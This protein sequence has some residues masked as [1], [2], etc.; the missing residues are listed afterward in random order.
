MKILYLTHR[1]PPEHFRGTEVYTWELAREMQRRGHN[2]LVVTLREMKKEETGLSMVRDSYAE[3]PVARICK[4]LRPD[5]FESYFFDAEMDKMFLDLTNEFQP[6]IIHSTYFLGGLSLGMSL[7][8][9]EMGKLFITITDYSAICARGQ[10]LDR[11]LKLC[12]GPRNGVRC[13]YCLF[14][15]NWLFKNPGLDKWAREYL[16]IWIGRLKDV[17]ELD[18]IRKRNQAIA[19]I[20]ASARS[21]I[22]AHP[23]TLLVFNREKI[24]LS[25]PRLL[26]FGVDY[27][28][29]REHKKNPSD[30]LRIGFIGQ[31]LPHK[32]LHIL[33][34]ALAG[35]PEQTK[36]ELKIYGSL[37]DPA[38]K[39]YFDSLSLSRIKNQN[40]LGTFDYSQMNKVLEEIDLLVVPSIWPENCPL[41]P[42]YA[43][44]TGT[45]LLL[46]DAP[47]ILVKAGGQGI[48][49]AGIGKVMMLREKIEDLIKTQAWQGRLDPSA[50]LVMR[51]QDHASALERIY[52][53]EG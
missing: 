41:I 32:G 14:D 18:L 36:F 33:V 6:D 19:N 2:V 39:T 4:H 21:V 50:G 34:E 12:P 9:A 35:I 47:G 17:W 37:S 28:P 27:A 38:E 1:F 13:L 42:K 10:L 52:G 25:H 7:R 46:S 16:P 24:K 48:D 53:G 23:L 31:I 26:D 11:N 45:R 43:L 8:A 22:F 51:I 30:R 3:V 44:L 20:L 5:N 29:F 15:R 49:F 40:W